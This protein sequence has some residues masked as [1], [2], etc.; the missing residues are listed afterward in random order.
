V[1]YAAVAGIYAAASALY[2]FVQVSLATYLVVAAVLALS[3]ACSAVV[4]LAM[5]WDPAEAAAPIRDDGEIASRLLVVLLVAYVPLAVRAALNSGGLWSTD[6]MEALA[7]G[8]P[9]HL[10]V[11]LAFATVWYAVS[12]RDHG[13][14]RLGRL[15][16][17]C[18]ALSIYPVKGWILIPVTAVFLA[19]SR[20]LQ[21]ARI[22]RD[23]VALAA[24]GVGVFYVI[25]L[26]RVEAEAVDL[27]M[28]MDAVSSIF[29]H[30]LFYVTAGLRGL[31]AVVTG[32]VKL[33]GGVDAL[34]A[35]FVNSWAA[36]AG[37]SY[38]SVISDAYVEGMA[39]HETGGNVYSFLGNFIGRCGLLG[40]IE[41]AVL[42]VLAAYLA[43]GA[44]WR[45]RLGPLRAA[46]LYGTAA[47]AFG[48][49]DY[50]FALLTPWEVI[51][52]AL[53][54][55]LGRSFWGQQDASDPAPP[56]KAASGSA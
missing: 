32:G 50:Y 40:G 18:A 54:T 15:C 11:A 19:R 31:N 47:F 30:L 23:V 26:S 17:A 33:S 2:P 16:A 10:H 29:E 37:G 35:P 9:G 42:V 12:T 5:R 28:A 41:L 21:G 1:G 7:G 46:A 13:W 39:T 52:F 3:M 51:A 56:S 20:R 8:V 36:V 43:F 25:Y 4:A 22:A 27:E 55:A 53:A 49:F 48:W 45:S 38:T 24:V 44:A 6:S 14:A 34:L